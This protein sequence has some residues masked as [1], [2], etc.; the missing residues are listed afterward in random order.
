MADAYFEAVEALMKAAR[1]VV[2]AADA[3][4]V[5]VTSIARTVDRLREALIPLE[6]AERAVTRTGPSE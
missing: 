2:D 1:A 5:V 3:S 4:S 6:E